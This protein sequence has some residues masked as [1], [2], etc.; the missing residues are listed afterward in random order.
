MTDEKIWLEREIK[1]LE[2][3][4]ARLEG[5]VRQRRAE[6]HRA[7]TSRDSQHA[8]GQLAKA[9]ADLRNTKTALASYRQNLRRY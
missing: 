1:R 4:S 8:Q 2:S 6:V 5:F 3:E 7:S 9:A